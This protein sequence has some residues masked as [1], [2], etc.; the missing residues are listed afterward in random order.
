MTEPHHI[1]DIDTWKAADRNKYVFVALSILGGFVGLDHF[2]L[3][4]YGTALQ[5]LLFN[6][7][8]LGFWYFWDL[9]QLAVEGKKVLKEGLT[10]P[11]DWKRGIGRGVFAE[12]MMPQQEGGGEDAVPFPKKDYVLYTL[13]AVLLGFLGADH[14]YLGNYTTGIVK[15]FFHFNIFLVLFGVLWSIYD[16]FNALA[17]TEAILKDGIQAPPP[18]SSFLGATPGTIFV[19]GGEGPPENQ[20][21]F[22]DSIRGLFTGF[23]EFI[24]KWLPLPPVP[25]LGVVTEIAKAAVPL[26][27]T[28][29]IVKA[30]RE[31][32]G[33]ATAAQAGAALPAVGAALPG[34]ATA[35]PSMGAMGAMG[36]MGGNATATAAPNSPNALPPQ[37]GG[38]YAAA[39][40]VDMSGPGPAIAGVLAA[41]VLAG[42][43]KGMYDFIQK[44]FG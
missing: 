17:R 22:F 23:V 32:Q 33:T 19:G 29:P 40:A 2:Y 41:V 34:I 44:Q 12:G 39:A 15:L 37:A 42:G 18:L 4:S 9:L 8:G 31:V 35:M 11:F 21:G 5:K 38:A 13:L 1:S 27:V 30:I 14:M 20:A 10:S 7:V 16:G 26:V 24:M 28:P 36:A 25:N 43:L 3:R 6:I